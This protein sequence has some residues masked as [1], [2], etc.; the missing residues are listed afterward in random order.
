[1]HLICSL[2]TWMLRYYDCFDNISLP[3]FVIQPIK[4]SWSSFNVFWSF[5]LIFRFQILWWF[6]KQNLAKCCKPQHMLHLTPMAGH[7]WQRLY[8]HLLHVLLNTERCC[9]NWF[10]FDLV[11]NLLG[12]ADHDCLDPW[13]VLIFKTFRYSTV[14]YTLSL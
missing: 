12:T 11:D 5:R 4:N 7:L 8:S 3:S 9:L 13:C 14:L 6:L 10:W 2:F 1:M